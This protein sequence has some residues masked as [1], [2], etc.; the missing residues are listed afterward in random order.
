MGNNQSKLLEPIDESENMSSSNG[1][2]PMPVKTVVYKPVK[3]AVADPVTE[4]DP[5]SW[6]KYTIGK[7]HYTVGVSGIHEYD[8][9]C[10]VVNNENQ[11]EEQPAVYMKPVK[12][13]MTH[14]F[15]QMFDFGIAC[16]RY[17]ENKIIKVMYPKDY[18]KNLK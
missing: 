7:K 13:V 2:I 12:K 6:V 18:A 4:A 8:V 14:E 11:E 16:D 10:L 1:Y 17:D 15:E 3:T 5:K 9:Y